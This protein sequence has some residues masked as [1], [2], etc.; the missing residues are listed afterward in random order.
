MWVHATLL[1]TALGCYTD[2]VG[3]LTATDAETYYREMMLVAEAF[4]LPLGAQ[5][6]T[7]AE[8]RTYFSETVS[9]L[10]VTDVGRDLGQFI[11]DPVLPLRLDVPARPLLRIHRLLSIGRLPADLGQQFQF[12]WTAR[13]EVRLER[14]VRMARATFR[15]LPKGVR[16]AGTRV[17]G[18][19][20]LAVAD[21]HVRQFEEASH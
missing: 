16:T 12:T 7:L 3:P 15:A 13:D 20:L 19:Y 4:G 14:V 8:F 1:D 11:V 6:A 9:S 2:F 10:S 18:R 17:G 21:R 5:P